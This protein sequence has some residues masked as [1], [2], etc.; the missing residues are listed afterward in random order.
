M[1]AA[2]IQRDSGKPDSAFDSVNFVSHWTISPQTGHVLF[3]DSTFP[4]SAF[5]KRGKSRQKFPRRLEE[6]KMFAMLSS[7]AHVARLFRFLPS[8]D[9]FCCGDDAIGL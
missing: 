7:P 5:Y 1:S 6:A 2:L 9:S 4:I 8:V 3:R